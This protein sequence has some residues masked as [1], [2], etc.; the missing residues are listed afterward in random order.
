MAKPKVIITGGAGFIGSHTA[1]ELC[2]AGYVPVVVDNFGNSDRRMVKRVQEIAGMPFGVH[3]I[4]C[5]DR[6]ALRRMFADEGPCFGVIHF[7]AHKAV[8]ASV[9]EAL[10]YYDN[11]LG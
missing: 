2:A 5:R 4:D 1:V 9:A 8:G 7:A 10:G 11:K 6:A 3:E